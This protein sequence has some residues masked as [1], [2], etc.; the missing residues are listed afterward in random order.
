[1]GDDPNVPINRIQQ[2]INDNIADVPIFYGQ[3]AKDTV[4]LKFFVSRIDQGVTAL[5]WTQA[6]AYNYFKNALKSTAACWLDSWV[7]FNR[8]EVLEWNNVKPYFRKAFGDKID[9]MVFA[10]TMFGIKLANFNESLYDYTNAITKVLTLHT[11]KFLTTHPPLIANHGLTAAQQLQRTADLNTHG[12]AIHDDFQKEF[13]LWGLSK[14]QQTDVANKG[15]LDTTQQILEFLH[16][17]Q[18][19]DAKHASTPASVPTPAPAGGISTL[20]VDDISANR[21]SGQ[22]GNAKQQ[23]RGRGGRRSRGYGPSSGGSGESNPGPQPGSGSKSGNGFSGERKP[24]FC[25]YCKK[26]NHQQE[27]CF[28]RI[29]DNSPCVRQDGTAYFPTQSGNKQHSNRSGDESEGDM[30]SVFLN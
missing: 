25:V 30:H 27:K 29:K 18:Q 7:T 20:P 13:F 28:A 19:T 11:E 14:Q 21:A 2:R 1:M 12:Y 23:F 24:L 15:G 4:T 16:T 9:P 3:P 10:S 6:D 26:N 8:N 5:N 17:K 22:R